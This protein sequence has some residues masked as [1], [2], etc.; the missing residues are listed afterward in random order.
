[1]EGMWKAEMELELTYLEQM[2]KQLLEVGSRRG[3]RE[4]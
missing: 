1:M 2:E 4:S 3:D